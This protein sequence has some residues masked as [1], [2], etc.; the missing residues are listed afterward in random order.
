M[1]QGRLLAFSLATPFA[2]SAQDA[3]HSHKAAR[4]MYRLIAENE[5]F[6]VILATWKPGQRDAWHSHPGQ[7]AAYSLTGC[8]ARLH[9]PDGKYV[10]R[11]NK[12]GCATF[13]PIIPS[14]SLENRGNTECQTLIVE[15]T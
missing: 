8:E 7:R 4:D 10:D 15:K 5:H 13:N 12:K 1:I 2:A 3:S 11:S 14:H 6:R 9:R